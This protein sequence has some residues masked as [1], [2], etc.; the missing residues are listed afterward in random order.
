M[1]GDARGLE[2]IKWG[3]FALMIGDHVNSHLLAG[4]VPAL[5]LLGRLVFPLFALCLAEGLAHGGELRL[6]GSLRRL[7]V[8]G[9]VAQVPWSFFDHAVQLNVLFT[10]A[11]G[12]AS[13]VGLVGKS[14]AWV[15]VALVV[16][17]FLTSVFCEFSVVGWAVV[18]AA[19]LWRERMNA[20]TLAGAV[21][22]VGALYAVN[23]THFALLALP[24]FHFGLGG[25]PL[26][27]W[28]H[29]FYYL[30]PAHFALLIVARWWL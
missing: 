18:L 26:P 1:A 19:L 17:G 3:A 11:A 8:W 22:T 14:A 7:A 29:G 9:A 28:R 6:W 27:R 2:V 30:Y 25:P 21:F 13:Y 15:R 24:L 12:L 20:V 5:Y 23:G 16:G 4:S 10:L